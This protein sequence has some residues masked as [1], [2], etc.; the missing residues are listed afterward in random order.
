[1]VIRSNT[2][3]DLM[4]VNPQL[5]NLLATINTKSSKDSIPQSDISVKKANWGRTFFG[6]HLGTYIFWY[7]SVDE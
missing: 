1:M 7:Y 3:K 2:K 6:D 5:Y 4:Q